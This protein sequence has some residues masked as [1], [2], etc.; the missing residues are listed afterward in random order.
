MSPVALTISSHSRRFRERR[1][2]YVGQDEFYSRIHQAFIFLEEAVERGGIQFYGAATWEGF[3]RPPESPERL[4]LNRLADT[5]REAGGSFGCNVDHSSGANLNFRDNSGFSAL[6]QPFR[7]TPSGCKRAGLDSIPR[8]KYPAIILV[9]AEHATRDI[10]DWHFFPETASSGGGERRSG[11][12]GAP[13][14]QYHRLK[15]RRRLVF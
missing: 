1:F 2:D 12:P 3:R 13:A 4:S 11:P 9:R 6:A 8:A 15:K 7:N 14:S 10:A 5:A